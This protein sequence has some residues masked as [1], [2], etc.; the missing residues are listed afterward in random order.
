MKNKSELEHFFKTELSQILS[1]VTGLETAQWGTM[2][3]QQAIEHLVLPFKMAVSPI[4]MELL[5]P[6]DKVERVKAMSL[7]SHRPLP[8][9]FDNPIFTDEMKKIRNHSVEAAITELHQ[10]VTDF[11]HYYHS[12][13][14]PQKHN[15]F[16][17]LTYGEWLVF[18]YKHVMHHLA[19]F[20]LVPYHDRF[21]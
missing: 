3:M 11:M 4:E 8:K 20:G 7:M 21:E 9:G 17:V 19:Q 12:G 5:T 14:A 10:A 1:K 13:G 2:N 16:G 6:A 18:Q 15:L